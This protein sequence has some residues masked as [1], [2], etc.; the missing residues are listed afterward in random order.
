MNAGRV[1][2]IGAP[3]ELYDR[4]VNKFVAGFLGSPSMSFI[5]GVLERGDGPARLRAS[6][7]VFL[8]VGETQAA[9]GQRVETGIRPEHY[10]VVGEN[11][12]FP[13]KVEV[14]EPTGAETHVFGTI[15]GAAVRCV[16]RE[17]IAATPG[18]TL[19]LDV[20]PAQVH[21]F[22]AESGLRL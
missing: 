18:E 19:R 12:G 8:P 20:D 2:Q 3:L 7:G 14:V 15:A 4:P 5:P 21:V 16:F 9:S 13:F 11:G 10:R 6:E 22:D 1:E 17:R